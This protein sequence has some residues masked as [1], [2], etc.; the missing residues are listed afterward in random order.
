MEICLRVPFHFVLGIFD[1]MG[2]EGP[3]RRNAETPDHPPR[4]ETPK[5]QGGQ[6]H[7]V[8]CG[9]SAY[10]SF[11]A[12]FGFLAVRLRQVGFRLFGVSAFRLFGFSAFQL[13]SFSA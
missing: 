2:R 1:G 8:F 11:A 7:V 13:F 6:S 4:A 9:F 3:K 10:F 5:R 12:Y